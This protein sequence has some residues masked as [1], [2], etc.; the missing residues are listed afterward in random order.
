MKHF[1]KMIEGTNPKD[2]NGA[3][4]AVHAAGDFREGQSLQVSE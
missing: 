3:G 2:A 1:S 4:A